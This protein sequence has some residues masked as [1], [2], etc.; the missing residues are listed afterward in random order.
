M[1]QFK[2]K[3]YDGTEIFVTLWDD[4]KAPCGVVQIIHGM[5]EYA[6]RY[7]EFAQYLNSRGYIVFADDHRAHGRTEA[8]KNRGRH[9]GNIFKKTLKDE[10]FFREWL[11][12]K[13]NLPVF[14]YGHSYG[15]FIAQAIAEAGTDVKA[16]ALAGTGHLKHLFGLGAVVLAPIALVASRWRP[17]VNGN[18]DWVNSLPQRRQEMEA[19]ELAHIS[20]S[21]GFIHSLSREGARLY[22]KRNLQKLTPATS[23]ALFCGKDDPIGQKGKGVD[24]LYNMYRAYGVPCEVNLYDGA[25]HDIAYECCAGQVQSD[26]A[27]FFDK[28]I[29]YEQATI[30][31]IME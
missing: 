10:L 26:V 19:D 14:I 16:I 12:Q 13:Y 9:K 30:D 7:A 3:S 21:I 4:V 29:I 24:K 2:L 11:K 20:M 6:G 22:H 27:D 1:Q 17:K 31:E 8:P 23:I 28:F 25:R 15:S 18:I 5:S